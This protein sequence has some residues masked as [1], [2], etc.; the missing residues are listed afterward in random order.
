MILKIAGAHPLLLGRCLCIGGRYAKELPHGMN[1]KFLEA[2]VNGLSENQP[3]CIRISSIK[4]LYWFCE[5]ASPDNTS[6]SGL[7]RPQLSN[8]SSG[9]FTIFNQ[10]SKE[11]LTLI[12]DTFSVLIPVIRCI[13]Y[14]TNRLDKFS[15]RDEYFLML[16]MDKSFTASIENKI[17]P[18]T[19]AAFLKFHSDPEI[20]N[21]CQDIFKE[22]SENPGCVSPMQT[23]LVPTL[24]NMMRITPSEKLKEG[25]HRMMLL[26]VSVG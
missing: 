20:V 14:N 10:S 13:V 23:R 18:L 2:T 8:I 15:V 5:A 9:L 4:T 22:L 16:Q 12:L 26:T 1:S 6:L 7:L 3:I 25:K 17:C 11:I 19:I 21:L 24:I